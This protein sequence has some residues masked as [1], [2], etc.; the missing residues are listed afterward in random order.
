MSKIKQKTQRIIKTKIKSEQQIVK[1][2]PTEKRIIGT[3][4]KKQHNANRF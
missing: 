4:E 1:Q 2:Q 3:L